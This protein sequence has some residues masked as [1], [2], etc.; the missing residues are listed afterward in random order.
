MASHPNERLTLWPC[1][2]TDCAGRA[3]CETG[4][5]G[6]QPGSASW[7]HRLA[8][9]GADKNGQQH[10][11]VPHRDPAP[12]SQVG[13]SLSALSC[14]A[15]YVKFSGL[16]EMCDVLN[17][18]VSVECGMRAVKKRKRKRENRFALDLVL[19]SQRQVDCKVGKHF[20]RV[21]FLLCSSDLIG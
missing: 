12:F 4:R 10:E 17:A 6:H 2:P 18:G 7:V 3:G 1:F 16:A 5:L 11:E 13:K 19:D 21:E 9:E 15:L 14:V 8:G 20:F